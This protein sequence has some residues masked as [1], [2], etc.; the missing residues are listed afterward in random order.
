MDTNSEAESQG[1]IMKDQEL[2]NELRKILD[3][4]QKNRDIFFLI[5]KIKQD[6]SKRNRVLAL[7]KKYNECLAWWENIDIEEYLEEN[8]FKAAIETIKTAVSQAQHGC[9]LADFN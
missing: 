8:N 2:I 7:Q 1:A 6:S 3:S 4:D 9:F 5:D